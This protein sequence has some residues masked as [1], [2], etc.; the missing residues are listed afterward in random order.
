M[1][2]RRLLIVDDE[3]RITQAFSELFSG[4]Y[5]VFTSND[6]ARAMELIAKHL[7][8]LIVLDWRLRGEVEGKDVLI[9]VK[10]EFPKIPVY[11]VTASIHFLDE[12]KGAGAD[13]CLLKPC[14]DL[15]ERVLSALPPQ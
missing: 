6:G 10:R 2:K 1:K 5:E 15:R 4:D 13:A 3:A 8:E 9:F 7:P 14:S 12:M 11:V